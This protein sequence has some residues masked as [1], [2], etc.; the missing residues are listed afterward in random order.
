MQLQVCN[1]GR[2]DETQA[3]T[4]SVRSR[5]DTRRKQAEMEKEKKKEAKTPI[6]LKNVNLKKKKDDRN[7]LRNQRP[8]PTETATRALAGCEGR[9]GCVR[10]ETRP[11]DEDPLQSL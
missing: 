9:L 3:K 11:R 4:I 6:N 7:G 8:P 5:A 10:Q 2:T 1:K